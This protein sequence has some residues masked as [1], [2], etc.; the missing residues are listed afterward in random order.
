MDATMFFR[1]CHTVLC[2][3]CIT[4]P[5]ILLIPQHSVF[6][7]ELTNLKKTFNVKK[8]KTFK[9][10][11]HFYCISF[12]I[13]LYIFPRLHLSQMAC[14]SSESTI[15][16]FMIQRGEYTL[17]RHSAPSKHPSAEHEYCHPNVDL[18]L[19]QGHSESILL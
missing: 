2:Y 15:C 1:G 5:Y 19:G 11:F 9:I 3:K 4:S 14:Q 17:S 10:Q 16:H 7:I 18:H 8:I 6:G 13:Y 12:C